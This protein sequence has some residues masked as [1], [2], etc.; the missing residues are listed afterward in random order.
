MDD[1]SFTC[2]PQ[3]FPPPGFC[4]ILLGNI[5]AMPQDPLQA[6]TTT[7]GT[8]VVLA[9]SLVPTSLP[10]YPPEE[11]EDGDAVLPPSPYEMEDEGWTGTDNPDYEPFDGKQ[12]PWL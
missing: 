12:S 3:L 10:V 5:V 8:F 1:E 9:C 11:L 6:L 4:F 2:P 7:P